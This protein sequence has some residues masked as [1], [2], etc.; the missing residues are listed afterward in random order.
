M[1]LRKLNPKAQQAFF[2]KKCANIFVLS[3]WIPYDLT[4][5]FPLKDLSCE[6]PTWVNPSGGKDMSK[7]SNFHLWL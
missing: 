4:I 3:F 5:F 2:E 6:D 7:N 1:K